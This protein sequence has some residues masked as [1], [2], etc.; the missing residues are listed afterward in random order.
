M[1]SDRGW[2][3]LSEIFIGIRFPA[4]LLEI[5]RYVLLLWNEGVVCCVGLFCFLF[6]LNYCLMY[7]L[8][9]NFRLCDHISLGQLRF[10][11]STHT[12]THA[13]THTHTHTHLS[14]SLSL[15]TF[16][17]QGLDLRVRG[18]WY[19]FK[20]QLGY[21]L[22]LWLILG[23]ESGWGFR[24]NAYLLSTYHYCFC[25]RHKIPTN[26]QSQAVLFGKRFPA[27]EAL[28]AG[29][30]DLIT[31]E[32][33]LLEDA[34]MLAN[35]VLAT[36][37]FNRDLLKTFKCDLYRP[38]LEQFPEA[39]KYMWRDFMQN[40]VFKYWSGIYARVLKVFIITIT[41]SVL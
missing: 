28:H 41:K 17:H 34:K 8:K 2:L 11:H 6:F 22:G 40:Y 4:V 20:D 38:I 16:Q 29:I 32:G 5:L 37:G 12:H 30:V 10:C 13:H 1:R 21:I 18:V 39:K 3:S 9:L 24:V 25:F 7:L 26:H 23:S 14:L 35:R 15:S 19:V 36:Q 27:P 31:E 33:R